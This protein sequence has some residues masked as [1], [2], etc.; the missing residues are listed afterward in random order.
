M[1][2]LSPRRSASTRGKVCMLEESRLRH[3]LLS[4]GGCRSLATTEDLGEDVLGRRKQACSARPSARD[5]AAVGRLRRW[6][7][8]HL[9]IAD[10]LNVRTRS[11]FLSILRRRSDAKVGL[12]RLDV[13]QLG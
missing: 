12:Y 3:V 8:E 4:T 5:G 6:V 2:P 7:H 11:L 9:G 13:E 10:D 1:S